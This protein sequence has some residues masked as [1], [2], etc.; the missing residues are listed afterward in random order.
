[1]DAGPGP[2]G[3]LPGGRAD[4]GH[5]VAPLLVSHVGLRRCCDHRCA[6]PGWSQLGQCASLRNAPP[7][8]TTYLAN[9]L[10]TFRS[11]LNYINL[12]LRGEE[13]VNFIVAVGFV[14][15]TAYRHL[16]KNKFSLQHYLQ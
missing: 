2:H 3:G 7:S 8:L 6:L 1:M 14:S 5:P 4:P 12:L 9:P 13:T 16:K 11:L 15:M 10:T